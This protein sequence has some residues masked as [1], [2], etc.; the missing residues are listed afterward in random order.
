MYCS[1]GRAQTG[2]DAVGKQIA[3]PEGGEGVTK[4][5]Q[6]AQVFVAELAKGDEVAHNLGTGRYAWVHLIRGA[7][8]VNGTSLRTGDAA[9]ISNEQGLKIIGTDSAS[10]VL[11]FDLA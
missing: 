4:I 3:G 9:A 7:V 10:E 8:S 1:V 5:N 2:P 6:N 11:L